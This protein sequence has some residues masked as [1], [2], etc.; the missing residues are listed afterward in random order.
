MKFLNDVDFDQNQLLNILLHS[1]TIPP[2]NPLG[3]Q[4]WYN[5]NPGWDIL[6]YW[7]ATRN[8]WLSVE[9][10]H[11]LYGRASKNT[12]SQYLRIIETASSDVI[13]PVVR[14]DFTV[15]S[16]SSSTGAI[17]TATFGVRTKDVSTGALSINLATLTQTNARVA[18]DNTINVQI[19]A[20]VGLAG[21]V[22]G[23][24]LNNPALTIFIKYRWA[25]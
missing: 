6:M 16:M 7:D 10:L 20:P 2:L 8:S 19:S 17:N 5:S 24:G 23:T 18:V 1:G 22:T 21:Y 9:T 15:I 11:Y 25:V 3:G 14:R 4:F 13:N 12:G